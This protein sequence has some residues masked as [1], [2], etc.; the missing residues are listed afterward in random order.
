M[1]RKLFSVKAL[2]TAKKEL[3]IFS[4]F[5]SFLGFADFDKRGGEESFQ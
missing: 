2:K 1:L 4:D 3:T 5:F